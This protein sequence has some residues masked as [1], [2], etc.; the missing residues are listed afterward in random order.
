[1]Y[2]GRMKRDVGLFVILF[3]A[4]VATAN[5]LFICLSICVLIFLAISLIPGRPA[6]IVIVFDDLKRSAWTGDLITFRREIRSAGGI[7]IIAF[8]DDLPDHFR[9]EGGND[10]H[11]FAKGSGPFQA[12]VEYSVR[13][14]KRGVYRMEAGR[15]EAMQF[16]GLEQTWVGSSEKELEIVVRPR[17]S[18]LRRLRDPRVTSRIP[19]P[20]GALQ[21]IGVTTTDVKEIR[22][23]RDGDQYRHINWKATAKREGTMNSIPFVNDIEKEG[24]KTVWLFLDAR[25]WMRTGS[26]LENAFEYAIQATLGISQFYLSRNCSVGVSF[27]HC[28][29]DILPDS[30]RRQSFRIARQLITVETVAAH[31]GTDR[32]VALAEAV[33]SIRGH[34]HGISPFFIVVT[35]IGKDNAADLVSGIHAMWK[36]SPRGMRPQILVLH[37]R[38][39]ELAVTGECEKPSATLVD[40][41]TAPLV[42][43]VRKAGAFVIPWNPASQSLM[44]VMT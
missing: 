33:E 42:R 41:E 38:G 20:P 12:N 24:R 26:T 17:P 25:E 40:L 36:Y 15:V 10:F 14:T 29:E 18:S 3:L 28:R 13:C 43:V 1:M 31:C 6:G 7:G 32:E 9:L 35:M 34:L 27:Y 39:Y 23:Y 22:E 2:S 44:K 21:P 8:D 16:S 11:V 5:I 37:V 4:G 19:M 30:G